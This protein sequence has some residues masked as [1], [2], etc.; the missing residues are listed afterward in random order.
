LRRISIYTSEKNER[1]DLYYG[2][3]SFSIGKGIGFNVPKYSIRLSDKG[4]HTIDLPENLMLK[5]KNSFWIAAK[6]TAQSPFVVP[7][8]APYPGITYPLSANVGEGYIGNGTIFED[9]TAIRDNA[10]IV[11]RATTYK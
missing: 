2:I 9:L 5:S 8:E 1:V 6:Y 3:G 7:I 4:Y 10:S 11:L